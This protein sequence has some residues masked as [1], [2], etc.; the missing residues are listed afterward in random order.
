MH[1]IIIMIMIL[2]LKIKIS[3]MELGNKAIYYSE[4]GPK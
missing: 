1:K 4:F 2:V 3:P